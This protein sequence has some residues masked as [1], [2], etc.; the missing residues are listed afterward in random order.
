MTIAAEPPENDP[1]AEVSDE[2]EA[3]APP[4]LIDRAHLSTMTG[5]DTELAQEVIEIFRHQADL[6][7]R[8]LD[9]TA[10][11]R[12][13]ADAAHAIKGAALSLGA[14][15]LVASCK[16]A[17]EAGR[18]HEQQPVSHAHAAIYLSQIKDDLGETLE[19]AAYLTHELMS[20]KAL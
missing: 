11:P 17:E 2:P 1:P 10:P 5:G 18:A 6:W 15:Q 12:Q 3:A 9:A 20:G 19:A 8:M 13:W 4:K 7:S 14:E 16:T